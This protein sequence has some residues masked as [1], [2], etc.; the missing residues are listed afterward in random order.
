MLLVKYVWSL[1]SADHHFRKRK[2]QK[3]TFFHYLKQ[4]NVSLKA[5][6]C[7][8]L[9]SR[10]IVQVYYILHRLLPWRF[11]LFICELKPK[12]MDILSVKGLIS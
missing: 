12:P 8:E 7:P 4:E 3:I 1:L 5:R 6:M 10:V 2:M 9:T 11:W